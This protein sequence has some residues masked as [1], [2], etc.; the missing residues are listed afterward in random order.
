MKIKAA[1]DGYIA[2]RDNFEE[3]EGQFLHA[4]KPVFSALGIDPHVAQVNVTRMFV[5]VKYQY[6]AQGGEWKDGW[7]S[8]PREIFDEPLP[9]CAVLDW[10]KKHEAEQWD[11]M[12]A[13]K[14]HAHKLLGDWLAKNGVKL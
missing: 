10:K 3:A 6:N 9:Q 11:R 7:Y 4:M 14:V 2:A 1:L 13:D 12:I 8:I 5:N